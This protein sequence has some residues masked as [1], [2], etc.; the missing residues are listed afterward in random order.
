MIMLLLMVLISCPFTAFA[1]DK[2]EDEYKA[3]IDEINSE[4][5]GL[6]GDD[7]QSYLRDKGITADSPEAAASIDPKDVFESVWSAFKEELLRPAKMLGRLIAAAAVCVMIK[8]LSATDKLEQVF[9]AVSAL[10]CVLIVSDSLTDSINA[11]IGSVNS[12]NEF[13]ISYIPVFTGAATASGNAV[14]AAGY[15]SV[16]FFVCEL[17]AYTSSKLLM[18]LISCVTALS[19]ISAINP[20]LN[21]GKAAQSVKG[22]VTKALGFIMLIFTALMTIT[23]LSGNA[24]DTLGSKTIRFAASSFIPVIGS[25]VSEA[26]SAV[27]SSLGVIRTSVGVIGV[28]I[29]FIIVLRPLLLVIS[30]KIAVS[31]AETLHSMFSLESSAGILSG[32]NSVLSIAM[33]I[34]IAYSLFFITATSVILLTASG[35]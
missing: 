17:M 1:E 11:L 24:A 19:F 10:V 4:L 30:M 28:I 13:M 2:Q 21:L 35:G 29:V 12:I 25:S 16:M 32:I 7:A 6:G 22:F 3:L 9:G 5:E 34:V 8:G 20:S 26:Y 33:S 15:Y 18:P 14:S 23:G 31:L 27:K